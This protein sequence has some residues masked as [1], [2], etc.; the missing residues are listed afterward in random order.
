MQE[1]LPV[2]LGMLIGVGSMRFPRTPGMLATFVTA[3][4]LAGHAAS[5]MNGELAQHGWFVFMSVDS[6]LVWVGAVASSAAATSMRRVR[7]S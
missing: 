4:I 2:A 7:A 6:L 3:C 5:A 1:F